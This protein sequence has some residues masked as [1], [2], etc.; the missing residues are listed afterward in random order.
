MSTTSPGMDS[1]AFCERIGL[2]TVVRSPSEPDGMSIHIPVPPSRTLEGLTISPIRYPVFSAP[3]IPAFITAVQSGN[4]SEPGKSEIPIPVERILT[5]PDSNR[6]RNHALDINDLFSLGSA[7][8]IRRF[9]FPISNSWSSIPPRP[10]QV[11][12]HRR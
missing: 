2:Q 4:R 8:A 10:R 7:T 9:P 12:C 3:Q 1:F 6:R 11:L 5:D